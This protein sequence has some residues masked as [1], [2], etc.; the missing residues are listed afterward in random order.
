M[1]QTT[2][3]S[4]DPPRQL[5][6]LPCAPGGM[7]LIGHAWPLLRR[8]FAFLESLRNL[9]EIV[10]V[11][12]G[13]TP[14]Y[15]LTRPELVHMI[16]TTKARC[17]QRAGAFFDRTR[18]LIGNGLNTSEGEFH[19]RQRRLMQPA[20]HRNYIGTYIDLMRENTQVLSDSWRDDQIIDVH[21]AMSDLV[22]KNTTNSMFGM[23]LNPEMTRTVRRAVPR[24]AEDALARIQTPK[25][26]ERFPIPA[27]R[28]FDHALRELHQIIDEIVRQRLDSPDICDDLLGILLAATGPDTGQPISLE[29]VHDEVITILFAGVLTTVA[30]LSW[31]F[32]ELDRFPEVQVRVLDEVRAVLDNGVPLSETLDQLDYTRRAVQ[33]ILRLH[34]S[35]IVARR[36]TQPLELAGVALPAGTDLGYSPYALHREPNV[37][38]DP[39]RVDPDRWLPERARSIPAGAFIP[40]SEGRHRCLGEFFAWAEILVAIVLL[41]PRW[42]LRLAPGQV[43]HEVNSSHPRLRT[44]HMCATSREF[45]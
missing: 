13:K 15:M 40:F 45:R 30:T 29:Q 35:L 21:E 4:T 19:L 3:P 17:V 9:G 36:V 1:R 31:L 11:N 41:L 22:M 25:S 8:P 34:P 43:V 33:E 18:E 28:R 38:P 6:E 26:L 42:K 32:Y 5:S 14:V 12:V 16:T 27:N 2:P 20:L 24:L 10:R 37:Y 44:L 23:S 39:T 7:P